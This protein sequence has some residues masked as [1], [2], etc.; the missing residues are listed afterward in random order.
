MPLE[1]FKCFQESSKF[2]VF[3]GGDR[4]CFSAKRVGKL[5]VWDRCEGKGEWRWVVGV[6]GSGVGDGLCRGF[7]FEARLTALP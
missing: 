3:G 2:K 1:M 4:V 6:P 7:V 5:A